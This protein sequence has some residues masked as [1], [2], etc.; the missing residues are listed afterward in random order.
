MRCIAVVEARMGSTRFPGKSLAPLVGLP[1]LGHIGKRL[2]VCPVLERMVLATSVLPRDDVL[3]EAG[4]KYG[5]EVVRGPEDN[6]LARHLLALERYEPDIVVR[7][8]GDCPLAD[9]DVIARLVDLLLQTGAEYATVREGVPCIHQGIDPCRSS[10]LRRLA[11]RHG[12]DPLVREHV[13]SWLKSRPDFAP[14]AYLE[15]MER[16]KFAGARICIDTPADLAFLEAVYA[17]LG[18]APGEADIRDVADLLRARPWL[19]DINSHVAQKTAGQ[20][21]LRLVIQAGDGADAAFL[22]AVAA[23]LRDAHGLGVRVHQPPGQ[24]QEPELRPFGVVADPGDFQ[25]DILL[26]AA[27]TGSPDPGVPGVDLTQGDGLAQFVPGPGLG[28]APVQT[29]LDGPGIRTAAAY[30]AACARKRREGPC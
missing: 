3:A 6:L 19:M 21:T 11:A 28:L 1:V 20:P 5:F 7:V 17:A 4:P 30:L 25:P 22:A 15:L 26:R 13:T 12:D 10:V 23:V 29:G 16:E 9:P 8:T 24:A 27:G 14:I 2:A 18:A